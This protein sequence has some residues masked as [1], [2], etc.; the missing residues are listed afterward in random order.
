MKMLL[1]MMLVMGFTTEKTVARYH[2]EA[3][4]LD[5]P[6]DAVNLGESSTH[7]EN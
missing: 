6:L 1:V 3:V 7:K 5:L 4:D 2:Q